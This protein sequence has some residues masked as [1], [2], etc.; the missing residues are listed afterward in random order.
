M[1]HGAPY[2]AHV[3]PGEEAQMVWQFSRTGT[4]LYACLLPGHFEAGMSGAIEVR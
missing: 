3:A 4:V 1:A 2:M